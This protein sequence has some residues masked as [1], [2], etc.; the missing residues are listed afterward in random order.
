MI[1]YTKSYFF[2]YF[3]LLIE[4]NKNSIIAYKNKFR[5][6][7]ITLKMLLKLILILSNKNVFKW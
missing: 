5:N 1:N 7:I 2:I 3:L 6:E 4:H